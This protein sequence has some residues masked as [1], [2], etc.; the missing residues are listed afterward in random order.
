MPSF[1][2]GADASHLTASD[3]A[4]HLL[5]RLI[6]RVLDGRA[7]DVVH[8]HGTGTLAND[9]VELR[10]VE[11]ALGVGPR[12]PAAS[13]YSHK[14][15]IGHSL[16]AAGLVAV[17]LSRSMHLAGVVPG[18]VRTPCPLPTSAAVTIDT[19]PTVRPVR[20]SLAIA[21][22][23]GGATAALTLRTL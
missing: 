14:G 11:A 15:A 12:S 1:A 23:F 7:V 8:A 18:N 13:V 16:G 20:R 21:A 2:L 17:V 10:A 22:G 4:G 9:P 19:R 3:P 5:Q 6:D